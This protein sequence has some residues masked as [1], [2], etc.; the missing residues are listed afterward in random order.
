MILIILYYP[1]N[2]NIRSRMAICENNTLFKV[3]IY[4]AP[5]MK[6]G[7]TEIQRDEATCPGHT[8]KTQTQFV[9]EE[10]YK[11]LVSRTLGAY[12][13]KGSLS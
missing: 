4:F 13:L 5:I 3:F 7:A 11:T 6:H 10:Q 2:L 12:M 8:A 9:S 1:F